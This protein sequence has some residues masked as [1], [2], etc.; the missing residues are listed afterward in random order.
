MATT[1]SEADEL[2]A[3]KEDRHFVTALARGL[4][5][6]AC[7]RR[8][9]SALANSEI[10]A[11]CGL[12]RSTVSRL[13]HTLTKLGYLHHVPETSSYRRGTA[14]IALGAN[15]LAGLDVRHLA[16]PGMQELAIF[17]NASVGLGVRDRLSMRYIE[18]CRGEAAIALNMDT[19]SRV[20]M[21]RSAMGRAY[22]ALC[23]AHERQG[24]LE[25][26]R[27]LDDAAWPALRTGIEQALA[28]YG[29]YGCA[30]SFGDW[31]PTVSAIA[32][33]FRPGGGVPP[34]S[35]NCG[36]PTVILDRDFLME[37][38]RPRLIALAASLEGVMGA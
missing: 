22:L 8:G 25:D 19:G 34:M 1:K 35:I 33:A 31:Q 17:A 16:R 3:P 18:C 32:V 29:T 30:R 5:V 15:A 36:A 21:A 23:D 24:L 11:R 26:F 14:L 28:D 6:L 27:A 37:E 12:A 38:V 4:D 20:P 9:E 10:A 7:F 13:T 2:A